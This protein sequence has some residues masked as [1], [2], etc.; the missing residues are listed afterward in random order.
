MKKNT[1]RTIDVTVNGLEIHAGNACVENV[2]VRFGPHYF[3][4]VW[5]E[6]G[7]TMFTVGATHHGVKVNASE[8]G[9]QLDTV[10]DE[11][12]TKHEEQAF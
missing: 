10:V 12:R 3:L 8:V 2:S 1:Q 9:G 4:E 5:L 6:K 11:L 7:Q